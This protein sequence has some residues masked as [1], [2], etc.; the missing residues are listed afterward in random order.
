MYLT[1]AVH[2]ESDASEALADKL[3][4][5]L[6]LLL[7]AATPHLTFLALQKKNPMCS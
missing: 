7:C 4:F 5:V 3:F 1:Q 2:I 6:P